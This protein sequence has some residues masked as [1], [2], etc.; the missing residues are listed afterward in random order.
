MTEARLVTRYVLL[1]AP[2]AR[3]NPALSFR[4]Q[5]G[6]QAHVNYYQSVY[7]QGFL[8]SGG[9]FL[10]DSGGMMV[11]HVPSSEVA[12]AIAHA[13]PAVQAELLTVTVKPWLKV[14]APARGDT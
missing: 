10:D 13:D 9:P 11:V 14:F 7:D 8:E 3:W 4:E 6:V 2:G 12:S 1:H 5:V